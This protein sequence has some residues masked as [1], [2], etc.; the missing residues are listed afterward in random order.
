MTDMQEDRIG[1]LAYWPDAEEL[2]SKL[3][4]KLSSKPHT[5]KT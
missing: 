3:K 2:S 4:E 5:W 1:L